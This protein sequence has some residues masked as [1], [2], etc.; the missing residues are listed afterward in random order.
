MVNSTIEIAVSSRVKPASLW[1]FGFVSV[2]AI[3]NSN[4]PSQWVVTGTVVE[5]HP[6]AAK[7]TSPSCFFTVTVNVAAEV[8]LTLA[9]DGLT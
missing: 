5:L 4:P 2:I 7:V 9:D 6:E 3:F 1:L 8:P